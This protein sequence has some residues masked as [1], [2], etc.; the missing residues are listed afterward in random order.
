M[1]IARTPL[2]LGGLI[3]SA[4]LGHALHH[5]PLHLKVSQQ[6]LMIRVSQ[7]SSPGAGDF[8]RNILGFVKALQTTGNAADF[9]QYGKAGPNYGNSEPTLSANTSHVFFVNA[10]D[11][12]ALF[13]VHNNTNHAENGGGGS[14]RTRWELS[15]GKASVLKSDDYGEAGENSAGTVFTAFMSWLQSNTDGMV[16]G[17]LPV[18]FTI[19]GQ[20]L[21]PPE[22]LG[23]GWEVISGDGSKVPLSL[24]PGQRV[25]LDVALHVRVRQDH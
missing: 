21:E 16:I 23:G 18:G 1:L 20:F 14:A 22:N 9:Y 24:V 17:A 8:D 15:G 6:M 19:L 3:L 12:L 11:G 2:L 13:V 4:T 25:R 7:E 5:E 10:A